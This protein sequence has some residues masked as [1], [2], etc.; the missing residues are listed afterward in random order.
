M[1]IIILSNYSPSTICSSKDN[2]KNFRIEISQPA[3]RN[4]QVKEESWTPQ[5][6]SISTTTNIH[7]MPRPSPQPWW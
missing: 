6:P 4:I 1:H 2:L 3:N 7:G 5:K